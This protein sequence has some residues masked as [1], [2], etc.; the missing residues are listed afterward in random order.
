LGIREHLMAGADPLSGDRSP[1]ARPRQRDALFHARG[2]AR[3]TGLRHLSRL[4]RA[5]PARAPDGRHHRAVTASHSRALPHRPDVGT[6][7]EA[8]R[9]QR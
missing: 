4:L 2:P 6:L 3:R 1:P 5:Q 9:N 8:L 7:A